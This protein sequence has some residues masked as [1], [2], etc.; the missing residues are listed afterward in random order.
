MMFVGCREDFDE[1]V[2]DMSTMGNCNRHI[3]QVLDDHLGF[4]CCAKILKQGLCLRANTLLSYCEANKRVCIFL[5][6]CMY[7][8]MYI[9]IYLCVQ[10]DLTYIQLFK[11][12]VSVEH[13][14]S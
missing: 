3:T 8:S 11:G 7:I 10:A 1:L 13:L 9:C 4:V 5:Y 2:R 12:I 14:Y 6:V